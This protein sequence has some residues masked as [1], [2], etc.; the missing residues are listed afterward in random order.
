MTVIP[1]AQHLSFSQS[2]TPN[3]SAGGQPWYSTGNQDMQSTLP[4]QPPVEQTS[5]EQIW[6]S[7]G[8]HNIRPVTPLQ[9]NGNHNA[10]SGSEE[11]SAE[12]GK[13]AMA[14]PDK[15]ASPDWREHISSRDGKKYY[16]NRK[17]KV[18]SW[19]KPLELMTP[20]E[21][22]DAT[23][24]WREIITTEGQRFYYNRVA[25]RSKWA[26]P[27]EVKLAREKV[28]MTSCEET[29]TVKDV[30]SY[31]S[32]TVSVSENATAAPDANNLSLSGHEKESSPVLVAPS[33]NPEPDMS[34]GLSSTQDDVTT[35]LTADETGMPAPPEVAT[36]AVASDTPVLTVLPNAITS[37]NR[38]VSE[39]S[40]LEAA[41]PSVITLTVST[42]EANKS[43]GS[44][45]IGG[46]NASEG[47]KLEHE[48]LV[49]ESKEEAKSAFKALLE[50]AN[51]ASDWT[52]DQAMRVII[53]DR[54]YGALR[55]LGERKQTF[56]EFVGLKRKHEAEEKRSRQKKAKQDFKKMLQ[57]TKDLTSLTRWSKA[58]F[59]LEKD[60]R[61][62]AMERA[63]DREELFEEHIEDLK[64][65]ERAKALEEKKRHKMEYLEFL[66]SCDFIKASSQWRKVQH[67]LEADE[68]CSRLE[69]IERFE[70]FQE[71]TRDLEMEEEEQRKLRTEELRK[72]ERKN[73]DEFRKLMEEHVANGILTAKS[74]WRDYCIKIKDA[75][76]YLAVHSNTTGSSA[77]VLF[78]DVIEDL[79]K[80]Y[81]EEREKIEEVIK[82]EKISLSTSWTF[83]D[84]KGAL[85]RE[86][87]SERIS[88]V[89]LKLIFD[90]L[91][92]ITK[93]KEDK[94]AKK[95][96]RLAEGVYEFLFNAKEISS[97]SKWEECIALI[98]ESRFVG[99]E[100]FF[101]EIFNKVILD[102]KTKEKEKEWKR[103]ADKAKKERKDKGKKER[104]RKSKDREGESRKDRH[105]T[106][107]D[108]TES[109][110]E[111]SR[112]SRDRSKKHKKRHIDDDDEK[113]RSRS[114][115]RSSDSKKSK[116]DGDGDFGEL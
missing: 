97:D 29:P 14:D 88:D 54:R 91:L 34:S 21:R 10:Q 98:E 70:T 59:M 42:E 38:G 35:N 6:F 40:P 28:N 67:R 74:H 116:H 84:F 62:Q 99:E 77:K 55:S 104:R 68:R 63:K 58:V 52:W 66:K 46:I 56:N 106:D 36:A 73:R 26:M 94:E 13:N 96:K 45:G 108:G 57:E 89:N 95:R 37:P 75:P 50:S 92:D 102:L 64:N 27:D 61:F 76:A 8:T 1:T 72:A 115:R 20:T 81:A 4:L 17:R 110:L 71:Y 112:R 105:K 25:K 30:Y 79:Q 114:H 78:D 82:N 44:S 24:D 47:K 93:E 101:R 16:Y 3:F 103:K 107:S 85:S 65:K 53:N 33:V 83:E 39:T 18:S 19:E 113:D 12:V 5:G 80:Q 43:A 22:A 2:D 32:A 69:K 86:I 87:T 48:P 9:Q 11:H 31:P 41:P 100:S 51:V 15:R 109:S 23:T 90:E 111:E 60:E 7:S 49:Y